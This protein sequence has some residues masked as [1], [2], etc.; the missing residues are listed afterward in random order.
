MK[1]IIAYLLVSITLIF[2][3]NAQAQT[4]TVQKSSVCNDGECKSMQTSNTQITM[5]KNQLQRCDEKGCDKY[6]ITLT[7]SGLFTNVQIPNTSYMLKYDQNLNFI[8]ATSL[9]L[10]L[11]VN[12]GKCSN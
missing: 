7:K 10:T 12:T 6:P 5:N 2:T 4:C 3:V 9:A 8:E 1:N 11:I